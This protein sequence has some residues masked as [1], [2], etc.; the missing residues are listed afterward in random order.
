MRMNSIVMSG[1]VA[2]MAIGPLW[3]TPAQAVSIEGP[4]KACEEKAVAKKLSED[5]KNDFLKSCI[6]NETGGHC[7]PSCWPRGQNCTPTCLEK[8]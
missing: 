8:N 7:I 2:V 5:A 6:D 4:L 1:C 3:M